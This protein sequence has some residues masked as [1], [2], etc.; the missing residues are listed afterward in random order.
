MK[1]FMVILISLAV[2]ICFLGC[3]T[4]KSEFI[5]PSEKSIS[6]YQ[7][8]YV[9]PENP[10]LEVLAP[11]DG[12]EYDSSSTRIEYISFNELIENIFAQH[13]FKPI[14]SV[15][16]LPKQDLAK[17][18]VVQW[19]RTNTT[20]NELGGYSIEVT[21]LVT[22]F[23]SLEVIYQGV[24]DYMGMTEIGDQKGAIIA[25]LKGLSD[26]KSGSKGVKQ[27]ERWNPLKE[28]E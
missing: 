6:E 7:Y 23:F 5:A 13:G 3:T 8:I 18:A 28:T 4:Y 27:S 17:T 15:N 9:D 26:A 2:T 21:V 25:A 12:E 20:P 24:G 19:R 1:K 10:K 22:D 16:N 14:Q 11:S